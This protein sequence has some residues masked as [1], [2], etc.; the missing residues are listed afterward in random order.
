MI[1]IITQSRKLLYRT[2]FILIHLFFIQCPS[3]YSAQYSAKAAKLKPQAAAQKQPTVQTKSSA[4]N[5]DEQLALH[6]KNIWDQFIAIVIEKMEA[7]PLTPG[8]TKQDFLDAAL[9]QALEAYTKNNKVPQLNN[10]HVKDIL[11]RLMVNTAL[12]LFT[13]GNRGDYAIENL[14][15]AI[16]LTNT[17]ASLIT[18]EAQATTMQRYLDSLEKSLKQFAKN[19]NKSTQEYI[20]ATIEDIRIQLLD[21]YDLFEASAGESETKEYESEITQQTPRQRTAPPQGSISDFIQS[22]DSIP[23][24]FNRLMFGLNEAIEENDRTEIKKIKQTIKKTVQTIEH[25]LALIK[26]TLNPE[27]ASRI[28]NIRASGTLLFDKPKELDWCGCEASPLEKRIVLIMRMVQDIL[29]HHPNKEQPLIYTSLASGNLLQDYLFIAELQHQGYTSI[30]INLIDLTNITEQALYELIDKTH[31]ENPSLSRAGSMPGTPRNF[32]E[33][34]S[35]IPNSPRSPVGTPRSIP[36]SPRN[37]PSTPRNI[38]DSP[39]SVPSTPRPNNTPRSTLDTPLDIPDSPRSIASQNYNASAH[40]VWALDNELNR[41]FYRAAFKRKIGAQFIWNPQEAA[42]KAVLATKGVQGIQITLWHDASQYIAFTHAHPTYKADV[43]MLTDAGSF[44]LYNV[45]PEQITQATIVALILKN[46]PKTEA[47][48]EEMPYHSEFLYTDQS[49]DENSFLHKKL[50]LFTLSETTFP[51]LYTNMRTSHKKELEPALAHLKQLFKQTP[52]APELT[53]QIAAAF[54]ESDFDVAWFA[55][56]FVSYNDI[57]RAA[58]KESALL[59]TLDF[60]SINPDKSTLRTFSQQ[61]YMQQPS[62]LGP[63]IEQRLL[64]VFKFKRYPLQSHAHEKKQAPKQAAK[65]KPASARAT[66]KPKP[67]PTK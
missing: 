6:I 59:Y 31:E 44:A 55:D 64:K 60:T 11:N 18:N 42:R 13:I 43:L 28:A 51:E 34:L 19:P 29:K 67:K 37:T 15:K 26:D 40:T 14:Q 48:A 2:G 1:N 47:P 5:P 49:G 45:S 23:P 57:V 52:F 8:E 46:Q 24:I 33:Q 4:I 35:S 58:C 12:E 50:I 21:N 56:P 63:V 38:P 32:P 36:G 65:R 3:L 7:T 53:N 27:A 25:Y 17:A 22:V 20:Q 39:R 41:S 30:D 66:L 9:K 61:S 16:A 10:P 54:G 62:I